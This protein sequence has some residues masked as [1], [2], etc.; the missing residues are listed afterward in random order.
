MATATSCRDAA[1][2][3]KHHK[4]VHVGVGHNLHGHG[5]WV[6]QAKARKELDLGPLQTH[7]HLPQAITEHQQGSSKAQAQQL[8]SILRRNPH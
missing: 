4:S 2:S 8:I 1:K 3:S 5:A 6:G 7:L